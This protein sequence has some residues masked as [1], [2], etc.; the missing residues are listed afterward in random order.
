M[1][2][3]VI[4]ILLLIGKPDLTDHRQSFIRWIFVDEYRLM[5]GCVGGDHG[6]CQG[7]FESRLVCASNQKDRFGEF[8]FDF[9][10][11]ALKQ[12]ISLLCDFQGSALNA[13]EVGF[14]QNDYRHDNG[15]FTKNRFNFFHQGQYRG[16]VQ[17]VA[18]SAQR[19]CLPCDFSTAWSSDS[20]PW[21]TPV[22][23][24][25]YLWVWPLT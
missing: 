10:R 23:H 9:S 8:G 19:P 21:R 24:R 13:G 12:G 25:W 22:E 18:I 15:C 3:S 2:W 14:Q 11:E 4:R 1:P 7:D 16:R 17:E 20:H 5:V 6:I